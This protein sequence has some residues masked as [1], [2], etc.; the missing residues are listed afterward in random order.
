MNELLTDFEIYITAK[1]IL[2]D[3]DLNFL[4]V[5]SLRKVRDYCYDSE[6]KITPVDLDAIYASDDE[7]IKRVYNLWRDEILTL[8]S[9]TKSEILKKG[10]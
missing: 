10:D 5:D 8:Y 1:A 7:M 3:I 4:T 9:D 2:F 6:V